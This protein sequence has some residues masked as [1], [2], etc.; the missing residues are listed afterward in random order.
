M[1][2]YGLFCAWDSGCRNKVRYS[3]ARDAVRGI[4]RISRLAG[5]HG[6]GSLREYHCRFCG[7]WHFGHLRGETEGR[8]E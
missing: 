5:R 4:L 1:S 3:R 8:E 7:G 6:V 2:V